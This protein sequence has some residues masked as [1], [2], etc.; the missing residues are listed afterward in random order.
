MSSIDAIA[1]EEHTPLL[2][3]SFLAQNQYTPPS[4]ALVN[5]GIVRFAGSIAGGL[6]QTEKAS[7][8]VETAGGVWRLASRKGDTSFIDDGPAKLIKMPGTFGCQAHTRRR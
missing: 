8:Y 3:G 2:T 7:L 1:G 6:S 5:E 4:D